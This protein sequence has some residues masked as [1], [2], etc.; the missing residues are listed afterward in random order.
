MAMT[1]STAVSVPDKGV[2]ARAI[3][4]IFAPGAT[5]RTVVAAPRPAIILLLVA[6]VTGLA[7]AAPQFT[8]HGRQATMAMQRQQSERLSGQPMTDAQ[9]AQM[10]RFSRFTPYVSLVS[11]FIALPIFAL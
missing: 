1:D 8:E 2:V 5:F 10:E 3:G 4:M 7:A 9:A 11:V 6:L